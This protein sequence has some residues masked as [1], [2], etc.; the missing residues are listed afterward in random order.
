[1]PAS[2]SGPPV[3]PVRPGGGDA[4]GD[5]S[6]DGGARLRRDCE[7]PRSRALGRRTLLSRPNG[8]A[9][10]IR[11]GISGWSAPVAPS[12]MGYG[13]SQFLGVYDTM[14][15]LEP[16][17]DALH[18]SLQPVESPGGVTL[19]WAL[20]RATV[21]TGVP[22]LSSLAP[23]IA[24][25]AC[26]T[27]YVAG[28]D[29]LPSGWRKAASWP[30]LPPE[31]DGFAYSA[32]ALETVWATGLSTARPRR[33]GANPQTDS[34]FGRGG[35]SDGLRYL[36]R[37]IARPALDLL[38]YSGGGAEA[39]LVELAG[40]QRY[41]AAWL[42]LWWP[43]WDGVDPFSAAD[44]EIPY[45]IT[46]GRAINAGHRQ[47]W[48]CAVPI[49]GP[50]MLAASR[51]TLM[52]TVGTPSRVTLCSPIAGAW[53]VA[54]CSNAGAAD[55]DLFVGVELR[56]GERLELDSAAVAYNAHGGVL[57]PTARHGGTGV[58]LAGYD[59]TAPNGAIAGL[60]CVSVVP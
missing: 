29:V 10:P 53:Y 20:P 23:G 51:Q 40:G 44:F 38:A 13:P 34:D 50:S 25:A 18:A 19:R 56:S 5:T 52:S 15:D 55:G 60:A 26:L 1:M 30:G 59:S 57:T 46:A 32:G 24:H 7:R 17:D 41:I 33:A 3:A 47:A 2:V 35:D 21:L 9:Y 37:H 28:V 22:A 42:R 27:L 36:A 49:K 48:H 31:W 11:A 14:P 8:G 43:C 16:Y 58:V 4:F 6:P 12:S 45:T 39:D 54:A